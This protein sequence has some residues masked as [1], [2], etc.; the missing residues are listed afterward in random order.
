[1]DKPSSSD[2]KAPVRLAMDWL[3]TIEQSSSVEENENPATVLALEI[4]S[5]LAIVEAVDVAWELSSV[6]FAMVLCSWTP[7]RRL[8]NLVSLEIM[9]TCWFRSSAHRPPSGA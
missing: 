8:D 9:Q 7:G 6:V 4:T 5:M 2:G 3:V 1:M